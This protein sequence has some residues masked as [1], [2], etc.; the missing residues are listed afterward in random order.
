MTWFLFDFF[1]QKL[2]VDNIAAYDVFTNKKG[3][4]NG[5]G[6]VHQDQGRNP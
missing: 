5:S 3:A 6:S 2:V 1:E 4:Q